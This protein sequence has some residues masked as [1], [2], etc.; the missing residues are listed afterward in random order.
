MTEVEETHP[1]VQRAFVIMPFD[2]E[3]QPIFDQLIKP[4]LEN[5]GYEVG[6]ADDVLDQQNVLRDI[7]RGIAQADLVVAE[8]TTRNPNVMYELGLCHGLGIPAILIAQSTD[9]IPFDLR[10]YRTQIYDTNFSEVHKLTNA[11]KDIAIEHR[12]G[13]V[14]FGSPV[15]DF[16]PDSD[17]ASRQR[18][19]LAQ[20]EAPQEGAPQ[21]EIAGFIDHIVAAQESQ[22]SFVASMDRVNVET[23]AI[24]E[25]IQQLGD[26]IEALGESPGP[27]AARDAQRIALQAAHAMDEYSTVLEEELPKVEES[28]EQ[29]TGGGLG[30]LTWLSS[31]DE[32]QREQLLEQR[33]TLT[34]LLG[35]TTESLESVRTYRQSI[36]S[37]RG[38]SAPLTRAS[39][40]VSS[41]VKRIE[42]ALEK[43]QSY[44][45]NAL[46]LINEKLED[47]MAT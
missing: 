1:E 39:R 42:G 7:V 44:C 22:D 32:Q 14:S 33:D 38:I 34:E 17:I 12:S 36:D 28:T 46:Q 41:A 40:R 19:K 31:E 15:T 23:E 18:E 20:P 43:V 6:R 25:K 9:E 3:F 2:S 21:P 37:L 30:Y 13:R 11:L 5:A 16:M 8:L 26:Q 35:T 47:K 24:G 29:F 45:S 27:G 4:A 10:T